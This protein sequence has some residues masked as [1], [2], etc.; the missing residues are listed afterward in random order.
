M[1]NTGTIK[2][3]LEAF[4]RGKY[5]TQDAGQRRL[6]QA[7]KEMIHKAIR[8]GQEVCG[9]YGF[10][11][12][13]VEETGSKISA[14]LFKPPEE[15]SHRKAPGA[16]IGDKGFPLNLHVGRLA[17]GKIYVHSLRERK[18]PK[19][20]ISSDE[21]DEIKDA[22]IT[23]VENLIKEGVNLLEPAS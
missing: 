8:D 1:N 19:L 20:V 10:F 22:V 18:G 15:Y 16:Y 3:R 14:K 9:A 17:G 5:G 7:T 21:P 11:L 2:T 6:L 23:E 4:Y 13:A 12:A